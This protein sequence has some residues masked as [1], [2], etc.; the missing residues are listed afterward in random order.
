[1]ERVY[2]QQPNSKIEGVF[3][4]NIKN[5]DSRSLQQHDLPTADK[6]IPDRRICKHQIQISEYTESVENNLKKY[7]LL[8]GTFS[9]LWKIRNKD[10]AEETNFYPLYVS[11]NH[12]TLFKIDSF[13]ADCTIKQ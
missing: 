11:E 13:L 9:G 7:Y 1:M 4:L 8:C 3:V 5:L 6:K 10:I 12:R 2:C